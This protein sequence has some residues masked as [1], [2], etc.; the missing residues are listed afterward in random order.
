MVE[1]L[2]FVCLR[3][4]SFVCFVFQ[5]L[6]CCMFAFEWLKFCMFLWLSGCQFRTDIVSLACTVGVAG[7]LWQTV[8]G[9]DRQ[10]GDR[11]WQRL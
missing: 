8:T 11:R 3:G 5:W 7:S 9:W 6:D 10:A 2:Y 1:V 4:L